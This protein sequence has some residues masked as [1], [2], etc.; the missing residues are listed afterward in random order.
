M[1]Q[2]VCC[3]EFEPSVCMHRVRELL[4]HAVHAAIAIHGEI[5]VHMEAELIFCDQGR[6]C[7]IDAGT[8][9]GKTIHQVFTQLLHASLDTGNFTVK[10][11]DE[12]EGH[13]DAS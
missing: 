8:S 12:M 13:S 6:S 10:Q 9:A 1:A 2:D 3:F 4:A 5:Q 7:V 11:M